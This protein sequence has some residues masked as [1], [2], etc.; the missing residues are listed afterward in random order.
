MMPL[1]APPAITPYVA[2][3][4]TRCRAIYAAIILLLSPAD[5]EP[6]H[7]LLQRRDAMS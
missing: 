5:A 7:T 1:P 2:A 4:G 6:R 3:D